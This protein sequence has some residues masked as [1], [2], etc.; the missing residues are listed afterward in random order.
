VFSYHRLR[1]GRLVFLKTE[2]ETL[3]TPASAAVC[4]GKN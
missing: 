2:N 4:R 3:G 1:F